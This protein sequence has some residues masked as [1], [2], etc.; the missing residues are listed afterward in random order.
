[1]LRLMFPRASKP[2]PKPH[3]QVSFDRRT[4]AGGQASLFFNLSKSRGKKTNFHP[5]LLL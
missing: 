3:S 1:M 4:G 5:F 2:Q